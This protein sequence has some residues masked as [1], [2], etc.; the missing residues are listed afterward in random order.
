MK[1]W[2]DRRPQDVTE[3]PDFARPGNIVFANGE[4]Y[5]AGTEPGGR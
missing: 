2:V 1:S 5:I 4:P 3:P